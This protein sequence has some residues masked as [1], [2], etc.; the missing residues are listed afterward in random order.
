MEKRNYKE[1]T[2]GNPDTSVWVIPTGNEVNIYEMGG[3][4]ALL[5]TV[6]VK[7]VWGD[8]ILFSTHG[9]IIV[10]ALTTLC[11]DGVK[12]LKIVLINDS[13]VA[14]TIGAYFLYEEEVAS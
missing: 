6:F 8:E 2:S 7:I 12:E 5:S 3:N 11:G 1:V 14:Q 9:D 13:G 10:K 4:A